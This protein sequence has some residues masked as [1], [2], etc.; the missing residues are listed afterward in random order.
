MTVLSKIA[1]QLSIPTVVCDCREVTH[2]WNPGC[3]AAIMEAVPLSFLFA[4]KTYGTL[5][6]ITALIKL[7]KG[8]KLKWKSVLLASMRSSAFITINMGAY[9]Y[10]TC[11]LRQLFGFY[12]FGTFY[13]AGFFGSLIAILLEEPKRQGMLT[14]YLTNLASESVFLQLRNRGYVR[15]LPHGQALLLSVA[16]GVLMYFKERGRYSDIHG[17]LK[18]THVLDESRSPL[19]TLSTLPTVLRHLLQHLRTHYSKSDRCEHPDSCVSSV[20]ERTGRNLI[21]GGLVSL[22]LVAL[23]VLKDPKKWRSFLFDSSVLRL[24]AFCALMPFIYHALRCTINRLQPME[25]TTAAAIAGAASGLSMVFYPNTTIAMYLLWKAIE[26][27]YYRLQEKGILPAIPYGNI[28][29]YSVSTGIVIGNVII[30]PHAVRSGYYNFIRSLTANKVN[31]FNRFLLDPLGF[32]SS[33]LFYWKYAHFIAQ[34]AASRLTLDSPSASNAGDSNL[35]AVFEDTISAPATTDSP[36]VPLTPR[37]ETTAQSSSS[38]KT[39]SGHNRDQKQLADSRQKQKTAQRLNQVQEVRK[40]GEQ[41]AYRELQELLV[42]EGVEKWDK[43]VVTQLHEFMH[44]MT[45]ELL[46][47]VQFAAEHRDSRNIDATDVDD[48]IASFNNS[49]QFNNAKQAE[50]IRTAAAKTNAQPLPKIRCDYGMHAPNERFMTIQPDFVRPQR[51]VQVDYEAQP[52]PL[53]MPYAPARATHR[54]PARTA[55]GPLQPA[56]VPQAAT[57]GSPVD[58]VQPSTASTEVPPAEDQRPPEFADGQ[59]MNTLNASAADSYD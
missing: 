17:I 28:L 54:V 43:N 12:F 6:C 39:P 37:T 4:M 29:L 2:V 41:T 56:A 32:H 40:S 23:R 8:K 27:T 9:L 25:K 31:L 11:K 50:Q 58:H 14:L 5:Y 20:V 52:P 10:F 47:Q 45:T 38:T 34:Q 46:D 33:R 42:K 30:E 16:L 18:H 26:Q 21:G 49:F 19:P 24:P 51:S 22:G 57:T 3:F 44:Q 55:K 59:I 36:V 15:N 53:K 1:E 48:A 35:M 7:S 13:L